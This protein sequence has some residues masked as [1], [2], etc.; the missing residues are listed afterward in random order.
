MTDNYLGQI[1][2]GGWNFA[3]SGTAMCNGQIL[4]I[5]Q[6]AALFSLLGTSFGGNGTT[7]FALPDL[8]GRA[9]VHQGQGPGL[10][11]YVIGQAAGSPSTRRSWSAIC[12]RTATRRRSP[13][14][15]LLAPRPKRPIS[16]LRPP[17]LCS[18]N[19]STRRPWARRRRLYNST[20]T[21]LVALGGLNVAGSIAVGNTGGNVPLTTLSPYLTV[22][23][24]ITL[25]GVF[26]SRS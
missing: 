25:V 6:N 2:Q 13:R 5:Q 8:R 24:V 21:G 3:P 17:A 20:V 1:I 14:R 19:P 16:R 11:S 7:I 23:A 12:R 4:P 9:M 18:P 10:S 15:R 22:T 26:P